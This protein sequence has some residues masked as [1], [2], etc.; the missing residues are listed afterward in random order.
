MN[1]QV[2]ER[3]HVLDQLM[4]WGRVENAL[5]Q[6]GWVPLSTVEALMGTDEGDSGR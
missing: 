1:T 5:G 2:G 4:G 3:L 6:V